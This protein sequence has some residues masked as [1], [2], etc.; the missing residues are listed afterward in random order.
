MTFRCIAM[1]SETAARFRAS[2]ADSFD[3]PV[4][5]MTAATDTGY[6]C[7]HCLAQPGKGHDVLLGSYNV[8]RPRGHYWSPSP[9]FLRAGE[10]SRFDGS[11]QIP[12]AVRAISLV[13]VRPYDADERLLY[14]LN[15]VTTGDRLMPLLEKC[16][17]DPRTRY[18]NI[19][20]GRPGCFLCRAENTSPAWPG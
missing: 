5:R 12:A 19:H 18:A 1:P 7:R 3:N 15:D 2:G 10:C 6:F 11:D 9:I 4:R 20:T 16:L 13:N 14:D 17:A 8:E